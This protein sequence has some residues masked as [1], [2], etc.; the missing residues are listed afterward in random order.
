MEAALIALAGSLVGS[1]ITVWVQRRERT[2]AFRLHLFEVQM[3]A[4]STVLEQAAGVFNAAMD[5]ALFVWDDRDEHRVRVEAASEAA[6]KFF[7]LVAGKSLL[8]DP[9]TEALATDL[10]RMAF[11]IVIARSYELDLLPEGSEKPAKEP[12]AEEVT[13]QYGRLRDVAHQALAVGELTEETSRS[14]RKAR[15]RG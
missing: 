10:G 1:A 7:P 8:L 11:G 5:L 4:Y 6:D 3:A 12:S 15:K 14:I 9:R 13:R 2:S